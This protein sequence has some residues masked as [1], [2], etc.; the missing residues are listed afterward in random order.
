MRPGYF[1]MFQQAY[2]AG[3]THALNEAVNENRLAPPVSIP[4]EKMLFVSA[5]Q[6][7]MEEFLTA[8][9]LKTAAQ[10]IGSFPKE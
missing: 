9:Q 10:S 8:I 4:L 2:L 6:G 7:G 3:R 1:G 5:F